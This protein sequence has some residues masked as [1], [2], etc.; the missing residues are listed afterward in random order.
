MSFDVNVHRKNEVFGVAEYQFHS[1]EMRI[2][3]SHLNNTSLWDTLRKQE[4]NK[5]VSVSY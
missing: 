1:A 5:A 2:L 3:F 4:E